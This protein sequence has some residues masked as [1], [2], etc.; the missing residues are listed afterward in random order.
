MSTKK[1]TKKPVKKVVKKVPVKKKRNTGNT[2]VPKWGFIVWTKLT[3]KQQLFCKH[4]IVNEVLR[5][6]GTM[7][8]NQAFSFKLEEKSRIRDL[9]KKGKE[10]PWSS[11]Y[12][13]AYNMCSSNASHLLKDYKIQERCTKLLNEMLIDTIVDSKLAKI[14]LNWD[15]SDSLNWIKEYNKLKNRIT[16]KVEH[17]WGVNIAWALVLERKKQRAETKKKK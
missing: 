13:K 1:E 14:I 5:W 4:Y 15:H 17:S 10:V 3:I 7:C 2:T 9:D 12:D 6:N 8:Y 16:D 11:D